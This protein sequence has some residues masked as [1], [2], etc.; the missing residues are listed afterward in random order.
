MLQCPLIDQQCPAWVS[1]KT[2]TV[3]DINMVSPAV[4]NFQSALSVQFLPLEANASVGSTVN[5]QT[6][7]GITTLSTNPIPDGSSSSKTINPSYLS[8]QQFQW[9]NGDSQ[10]Q[11]PNVIW[12]VCNNSEGT[13]KNSWLGGQKSCFLPSKSYNAWNDVVDQW[14]LIPGRTVQQSSNNAGVNLGDVLMLTLT[15]QAT[16]TV[17]YPEMTSLPIGVFTN[18]STQLFSDLTNPSTDIYTGIIQPI[19]LNNTIL[20]IINSQDGSDQNPLAPVNNPMM[21]CP[22][23]PSA[24]TTTFYFMITDENGSIG[25]VPLQPPLFY[26]CPCSI[27]SCTLCN[28]PGQLAFLDPVSGQKCPISCTQSSSGGPC[29]FQLAEGGC[30][31]CNANNCSPLCGNG[32][33]CERNLLT[34]VCECVDI[35]SQKN[36]IIWLIVIIAVILVIIVILII[37]LVVRNQK[38][39][40]AAEAFQKSL[41]QGILQNPSK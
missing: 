30:P 25:G 2:I 1:A 9:Q 17:P 13:E 32:Q 23:T 6:P 33:V 3:N 19:Q 28:V 15:P 37:L 20:S 39:K 11:V 41:I 10:S 16:N 21:W 24:E 14:V 36:R 35:P 34:G 4:A 26:N 22:T 18:G 40:K 38:E 7:L 5:Y 29:T 27:T 12:N 31:A 8:M